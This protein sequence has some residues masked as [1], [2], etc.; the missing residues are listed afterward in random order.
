[1]LP[2]RL[3]AAQAVARRPCC[4]S[5]AA[6]WALTRPRRRTCCTS[7]ARRWQA[8]RRAGRWV[9]WGQSPQRP[10]HAARAWSCWRIWTCCVLRGPRGLSRWV[11]P[12]GLSR[13]VGPRGLSRWVGALQDPGPA[14][15]WRV[16]LWVLW[17]CRPAS[18]AAAGSDSSLPACCNPSLPS[19]R[20]AQA[21]GSVD[22]ESATRVAEWLADLMHWSRAQA[23]PLCWAASARDAGALHAALRAPGALDWEVKLQ[24]G[25]LR[26]GGSGGWGLGSGD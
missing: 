5:W 23:R 10:W 14:L 3:G 19:P 9:C 7:P 4:R 21:P 25:V 13:W 22:A 16:W 20:W 26:V 24:V 6:A 18:L 12:R 17:G 8:A 11:G 1:M 2:S 15:V